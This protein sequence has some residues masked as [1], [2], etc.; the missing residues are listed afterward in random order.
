V[1][2]DFDTL[3]S[4]DNINPDWKDKVTVRDRDTGTQTRVSIDELVSYFESKF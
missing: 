2:I 3:G 4:G 1:V